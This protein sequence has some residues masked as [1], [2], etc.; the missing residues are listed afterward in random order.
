MVI[1]GKGKP[2]DLES[3]LAPVYEE[4]DY[5]SR[6]GIKVI[7]PDHGSIMAKVHLMTFIGDIP[8]VAD[9]IKHTGHMSYFGCRMCIAKGVRGQINDPL[10]GGMYFVGKTN[11]GRMRQ[12]NEFKDGG[13]VSSTLMLV[14][15][16]LAN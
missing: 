13:L 16:L 5:L 8:A 12:H 7:T 14:D 9:L 2:K 3:F 4:L 15:A 10:S 1:P 11:P 6:V